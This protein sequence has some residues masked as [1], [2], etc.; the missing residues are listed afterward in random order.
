MIH[1]LKW[2][3]NSS[4]NLTEQTL[5]VIRQPKGH[6]S[7]RANKNMQWEKRNQKFKSLKVNK[8]KIYLV[9]VLRQIQ[10]G[11]IIKQHYF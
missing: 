8:R 1:T 5:F 4:Q 3:Y 11:E 10:A 7:Q 6:C 9:C 2:K